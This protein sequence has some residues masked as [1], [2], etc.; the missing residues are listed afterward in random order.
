[1]KI[2]NKILAQ[3]QMLGSRIVSINLKNDFLSANCL[4]S[5]KKMLD[6]SHEIIGIDQQEDNNFVGVIRLHVAV[7]VKEEKQKY[8][9]KIILEGGFLAPEEMGK[10]EFE[11]MLSINGL[12]ALYGIARAQVRSISS[13][14]FADGGVLLPMIDV[15]RYSK[16][17]EETIKS[18]Q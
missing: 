9:L 16:V 5:G 13:Q 3:F 11:K 2:D 18:D 15:T 1:M 8:S 10:E 17:L 12:T 7:R 6:L 14:V 4:D